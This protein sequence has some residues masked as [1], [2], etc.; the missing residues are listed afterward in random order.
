MFST[1]INR[2]LSPAWTP[3]RARS[4]VWHPPRSQC[5]KQQQEEWLV[6]HMYWARLGNK[7]KHTVIYPVS[8]LSVHVFICLC[9]NKA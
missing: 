1:F 3:A 9:V 8:G 7:K 6:S 2:G 4:V 5:V